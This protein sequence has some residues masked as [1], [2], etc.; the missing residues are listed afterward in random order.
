MYFSLVVIAFAGATTAFASAV[1]GKSTIVDRA[2]DIC[3]GT[4]DNPQCCASSVLG[5]A[6]L[7]CVPRK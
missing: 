6:D 5:V 2:A 1:P 3:P 7:D 4:L